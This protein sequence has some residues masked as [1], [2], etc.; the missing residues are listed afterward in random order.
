MSV[1][2]FTPTSTAESGPESEVPGTDVFCQIVHGHVAPLKG[3]ITMLNDFVAVWC[4][5]L[6]SDTCAVKLNVPAADGVPVWPPVPLWRNSPDGG[7]ARATDQ[8][9]GGSPP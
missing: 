8:A 6:E 4:V 2:N 9:K 3:A 5:L 7:E 1:R